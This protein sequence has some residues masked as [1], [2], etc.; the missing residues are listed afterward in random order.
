MTKKIT[1][2]ERKKKIIFLSLF[3]G[4]TFILVFNGFTQ[5]IS[6][7]FNL[8]NGLVTLIAGIGIIGSVLYGLWL[9]TGGELKL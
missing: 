5:L 3:M 8:S 2:N 9:A 6:N 7:W 1:K 4:W